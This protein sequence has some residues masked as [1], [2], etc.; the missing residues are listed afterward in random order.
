VTVADSI[1]DQR[2]LV[3]YAAVEG[4]DLLVKGLRRRAGSTCPIDEFAPDVV[5]WYLRHWPELEAAAMGVG[6][7]LSDNPVALVHSSD[8]DARKQIVAIKADLESATDTALE[9]ILR[10]YAVT[11]IYKRQGRLAHYFALRRG[12]FLNPHM[13]HEPL[14]QPLAEAICVERISR[15]L[16]WYEHVVCEDS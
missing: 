3:L 16:G 5:S 10:W 4:L 2:I 7:S 11:R 13:A 15:T 8:P 12:A 1:T 6:S 9:P 14:V